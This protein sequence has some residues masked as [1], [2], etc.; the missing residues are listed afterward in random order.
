MHPTSLPMCVSRTM[1][2]PT[3]THPCS[4]HL[5]MAL[6]L[7]SHCSDSHCLPSPS[8]GAKGNLAFIVHADSSPFSEH[9]TGILSWSPEHTSPQVWGRKDGS[10]T[11]R[12]CCLDQWPQFDS[13]AV[14]DRKNRIPRVVF[15]FF[16]CVQ[17]QTCTCTHTYTLHVRI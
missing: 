15:W 3:F 11:K 6:P 1:D 13:C 5:G 7:S 2:I 10:G 9:N 16:T 12:A 17:W 8:E 4:G 14:Y